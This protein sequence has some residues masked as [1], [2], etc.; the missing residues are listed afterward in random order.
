MTPQLAVPFIGAVLAALSA[1]LLQRRLPPAL[2]TWLLAGLAGGAAI[3]VLAAELL[4]SVTYLAGIGWVSDRVGWCRTLAAS[5]H[6]PSTVV[7]LAALGAVTTGSLRALRV[8]RCYRRMT[9]E[10]SDSPVVVV[11]SA[12][13]QA[14]AVPGKPGHVHVTTAMLNALDEDGRRVLF[15]HESAHLDLGHHRF[16][17]IGSVAAA[18]F[19]PLRPLADQ[20]SF[21]TERWADEVAA[22]KIGDRRT[23]ARAIAA[24]AFA[25]TSPP[26]ALGLADL[27]VVGRVEALLATGMSRSRRVVVGGVVLLILNFAGGVVQLHHLVGLVR[28]VC[29]A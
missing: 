21:C 28:H 8:M 25:T 29:S 15:A 12:E 23:T 22:A 17:Q 9:C 14:F 19:P 16:V 18:L 20:I 26:Y 11:Q 27:G 10:S 5:Q 1:R 6:A 24:A 7:G 3:A 13:A 2:G 4:A